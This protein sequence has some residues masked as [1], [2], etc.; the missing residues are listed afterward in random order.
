MN[1]GGRCGQRGDHV[2]LDLE[3]RHVSC[4][5]SEYTHKSCFSF[6]HLQWWWASVKFTYCNFE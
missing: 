5:Q 2:A 1:Q 6:Y 3:L 4:V